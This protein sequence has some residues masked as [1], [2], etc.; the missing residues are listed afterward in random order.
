MDAWLLIT[1]ILSYL[2]V[3][4]LFY[5][6]QGLLIFSPLKNL[7]GNPSHVGLQYEAYFI[8]SVENH[9]LQLWEIHVPQD[10][11][12]QGAILFFHGNGGNISTRL[13]RYQAF[14]K[15]GYRVFA[16][17]YRGYGKSTGKPSE[18]AIDQDLPFLYRFLEKHSP[19]EVAQLIVYGS[20]LGGAIAV[21]YA[22]IF[23]CRALILESTFTNVIDMGR[24]KYPFL[25]MRL[26]VNQPFD[27]LAK[28]ADI[29]GNLLIL[30]SKEDETTPYHHGKQLFAAATCEKTFVDIKGKHREGWKATGESLMLT[31]IQSFLEQQKSPND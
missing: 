17:E 23:P 18:K 13:K 26:I 15:I 21:K 11:D 19:D 6:F 4:I 24:A 20:S 27:S 8:E 1:V 5:R 30:H 14:T 16:F 25:P 22:H 29:S 3:C 28:I 12:P 10:I 9:Q 7:T 31:H 2:M